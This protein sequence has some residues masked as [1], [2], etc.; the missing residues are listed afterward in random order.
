MKTSG[1]TEKL[2]GGFQFKYSIDSLPLPDGFIRYHQDNFSR[3][4]LLPKEEFKGKAILETGCGPGKHAVALALLGAQVTAVDLSDDNV[5][6]GRRLIEYYKFSNLNFL[7]H[8]LMQPL[9]LEANFDLIS[10]HNWI[11]HSLNP[12][13]VLK[14]LTALLKPGGRCYISCYHANTFRFFITQ[15]ARSLLIP[16]DFE[17]MQQ[18]VMF[19]FPS[20]FR[21]FSNPDDIYFENI[22]DDF[23]VPYCHTTTYPMLLSV[24]QGLG[25]RAITQAPEI[26]EIYGYDNIAL[27]MGFEKQG[28]VKVSDKVAFD[29]SV[30]EFD[31][32]C[33]DIVK[34]SIKLAEE[35]IAS[36]KKEGDREKIMFFCLGL[37]RL[38]A[39]TCAEN[40]MGLKH[41]LLQQYL[42]MVLSGNI[43]AHSVFYEMKD[44]YATPQG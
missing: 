3:Y 33:P 14:N 22:F 20:G 7:K 30:D 23:L 41:G 40:N 38:R 4:F 16:G 42:N 8:D 29:C 11:Q 18:L 44:F 19:V 6:R 15:I 39:E 43:K 24:M 21:G 25:Y 35:V 36:V 34:E 28:N 13:L 9:L 12:G 2:Y 5:E 17:Q 37:Y 26:G 27:R 31:R 32:G 1:F 10:I